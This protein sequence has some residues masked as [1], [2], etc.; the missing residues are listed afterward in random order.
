MSK[1]YSETGRCSVEILV[2]ECSLYSNYR[3]S[4]SLFTSF[5]S[6]TPWAKLHS[7]KS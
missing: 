1:V 5:S 4:L 3:C 7:S 2:G 6:T